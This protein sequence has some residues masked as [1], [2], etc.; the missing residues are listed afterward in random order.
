[1]KLTTVSTVYEGVHCEYT[2]RFNVDLNQVTLKRVKSDNILWGHGILVES[3]SIE[4]DTWEPM[5][6]CGVLRKWPSLE[7]A[8]QFVES[9][10]K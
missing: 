1:M 9:N 6:R 8:I 4:E 3:V 10:H 7:S 2:Y 5:C